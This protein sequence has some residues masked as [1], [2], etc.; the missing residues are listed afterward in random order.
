MLL[1]GLVG[2]SPGGQDCAGV[3]IV[4]STWGHLSPPLANG[5]T[6]HSGVSIDCP[7]VQV[8]VTEFGL[9]AALVPVPQHSDGS[10]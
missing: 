10:G 5:R 9:R 3:S 6:L 1:T 7:Y 8:V 2:R 4:P